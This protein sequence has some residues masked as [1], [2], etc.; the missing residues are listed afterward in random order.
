MSPFSYPKR[1]KTIKIGGVTP[2][3]NY[4]VYEV[5]QFLLH[6]ARDGEGCGAGYHQNPSH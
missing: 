1:Q 3:H 2:L 6:G 4:G 5:V